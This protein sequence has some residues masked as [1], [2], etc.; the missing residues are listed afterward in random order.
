MPYKAVGM[1]G[2]RGGSGGYGGRGD[3]RYGTGYNGKKYKVHY[4]PEVSNKYNDYIE[5]R[6]AMADAEENFL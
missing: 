4:N 5:F 3:Q 6:K 2:G 1:R